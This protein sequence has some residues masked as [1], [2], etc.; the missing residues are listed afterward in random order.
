MPWPQW[1]R[2]RSRSP[3]RQGE[4]ALYLVV[5]SADLGSVLREAAPDSV[6][7]SDR[8]SPW[9]YGLTEVATE[10]L[11]SPASLS[12]FGTEAEIATY[13][14]GRLETVKFKWKVTKVHP[15]GRDAH[16]LLGLLNRKAGSAAPGGGAH[17]AR[18]LP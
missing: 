17:A 10:Y 2:G 8:R 11:P 14:R 16:A 3:D 12:R 13:L 5:S 4:R 15:V 18:Q 1:T 9:V 7:V 6:V